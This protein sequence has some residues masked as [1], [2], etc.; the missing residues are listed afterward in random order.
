[1]STSMLLLSLAP[2]S[3]SMSTFRDLHGE[4]KSH[5]GL[6]LCMGNPKQMGTPSCRV[7]TEPRASG[8]LCVP[9]PSPGTPD[10]CWTRAQAP[11]QHSGKTHS[12]P[13]SSVK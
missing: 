13:L 9:C 1:M 7:N 6:K 3:H 11:T 5:P 10:P 12:T 4:P 8:D 2:Y